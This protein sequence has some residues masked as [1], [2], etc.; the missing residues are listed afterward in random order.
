MK[1]AEERVNETVL[2]ALRAAPDGGDVVKISLTSNDE[3]DQIPLWIWPNG[4]QGRMWEMISVERAR[5][6][7]DQTWV[8]VY[9]ARG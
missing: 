2:K 4:D 6:V 5:R 1:T 7:R 8:V 9:E 3:I